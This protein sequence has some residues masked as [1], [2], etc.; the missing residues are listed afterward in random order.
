MQECR[1]RI[2]AASCPIPRTEGTTITFNADT[3]KVLKLSK[4]KWEEARDHAMR[5]VVADNRMRIWCVRAGKAFTRATP[6]PLLSACA[7]LSL[8]CG[9]AL[10]RSSPPPTLFP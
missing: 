1:K 7:C 5:A 4:E 9:G 8:G 10:L 2:N 6:C 3:P